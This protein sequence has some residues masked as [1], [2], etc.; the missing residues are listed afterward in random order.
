MRTLV[1]AVEVRRAATATSRVT[2][3]VHGMRTS[4]VFAVLIAAVKQG[5]NKK[6]VAADLSEVVDADSGDDAMIAED[7]FGSA[8]GGDPDLEGFN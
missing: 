2:P 4:S 7:G 8:D 5:G 3:R 1:W 6:K